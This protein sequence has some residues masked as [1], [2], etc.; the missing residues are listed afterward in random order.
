MYGY[1][2]E[3][4]NQINGKKY[5]GK[6]VSSTFDKY[7]LGS[8]K[9]LRNAIDKYGFNNF[10]C[11][12]LQECY[13]NEELNDAEKDW[14]KKFNATKSKDYYNIADGGDG[15]NTYKYK[16]TV[17]MNII[18]KK[19]SESSKKII[20]TDEWNRNSGNGRIGIKEKFTYK[21][22]EGHKNKI[23]KSN[24]GKHFIGGPLNKGKK[25]INKDGIIKYAFESEIDDYINLG[26]NRGTCR[27]QDSTGRFI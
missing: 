14:I 5:I 19:I 26:W 7:Y 11:I 4:T 1:I 6:R 23:S 18:K 9:L 21:F 27:K 25:M 8:G 22:T 2:Y 10:K 24:K 13:G 20:H 17:E 16:S 3:T 15:G 12:V